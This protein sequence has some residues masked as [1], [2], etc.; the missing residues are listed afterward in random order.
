MISKSRV[1]GGDGLA[2]SIVV[3]WQQATNTN[4]NA[5]AAVLINKWQDGEQR[6][7][8]G[9]LTQL[10]FNLIVPGWD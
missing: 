10:I 7:E 8:K 9:A 2:Y 1:S 3:P 6:R 5:R 4:N